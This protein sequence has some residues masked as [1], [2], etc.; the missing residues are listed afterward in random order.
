MPRP[1]PLVP[2]VTIATFSDITG[3]AIPSQELVETS[4]S[5]GHSSARCRLPSCLHCIHNTCIAQE[6]AAH[7]EEEA[8]LAETLLPI[9]GD[10]HGDSLCRYKA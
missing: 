5:C 8:K 9:R 10:I 3:N 7:S 6:E 2:P 4:I 1:M